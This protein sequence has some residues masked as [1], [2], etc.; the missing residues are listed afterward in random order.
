MGGMV[1]KRRWGGGREEGDK[2]SSL[3]RRAKEELKRREEGEGGRKEGKVQY[4][5]R[6]G[7]EFSRVT[8]R[9]ATVAALWTCKRELAR[10]VCCVCVR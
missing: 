10:S 5:A 6:G 7:H 1:R 4:G 9:D 2:I 3:S 8:R